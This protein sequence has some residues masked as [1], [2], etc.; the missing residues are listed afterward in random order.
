MTEGQWPLHNYNNHTNLMELHGFRKFFDTTCTSAGMNNLYTEML[1][2]HDVGLKGRY[3]KLSPE[4]LLEGNDKNLGYLS[5]MESRVSYI[6]VIPLMLSMY[7]N[8]YHMIVISQ[9][10]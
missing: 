9:N 3:T 8:R 10:I 6:I 4:E 2:G 1:M 5:A 7:C